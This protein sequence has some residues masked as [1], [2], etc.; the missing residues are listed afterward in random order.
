MSEDAGRMLF[1]SS[2]ATLHQALVLV[3]ADKKGWGY[4]PDNPATMK[5]D[6]CALSQ[7]RGWTQNSRQLWTGWDTPLRP[8][9]LEGSLSTL[10]ALSD[11][12][13]ER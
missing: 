3:L 9:I 5:S 13:S 1:S 10:L 7:V 2:D 6:T 11:P 8:H 12:T 4:R